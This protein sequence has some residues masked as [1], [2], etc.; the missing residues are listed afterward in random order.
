MKLKDPIHPWQS[1]GEKL[2]T[3]SD[4][5]SQSCQKHP[6]SH[7]LWP[8][9]LWSG[10]RKK[11]GC[12][13]YTISDRVRL[14]HQHMVRDNEMSPLPFKPLFFLSR[15]SMTFLPPPAQKKGLIP[16]L[17]GA[18]IKVSPEFLFFSCYCDWLSGG[19]QWM[20]PFAS[21]TPRKIIRVL[22]RT[23]DSG[24]LPFLGTHLENGGGEGLPSWSKTRF[25]LKPCL[26]LIFMLLPKHKQWPKKNKERSPPTPGENPVESLYTHFF[27]YFFRR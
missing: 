1:V 12:L 16:M 15:T 11:D 13:F 17:T 20:I 3:R 22:S 25:F 7:P 9:A 8:T 14:R 27:F 21:I 10:S 2:N 24:R 6:P 18:V 4:A 5:R 19:K 23:I 26:Y